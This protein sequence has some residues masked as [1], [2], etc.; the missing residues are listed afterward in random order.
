MTK[1]RL[2]VA[3]GATL[4]GRGF[5]PP[6]AQFAAMP[7]SSIVCWPSV[8]QST[9]REAFRPIGCAACPSIETE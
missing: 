2:A 3:P 8:N 1:V 6:T 5:S 9:V 7:D 4:T